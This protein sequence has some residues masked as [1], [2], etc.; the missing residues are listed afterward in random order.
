MTQTPALRLQRF[1][2]VVRRAGSLLPAAA[3]LY[4]CSSE[5][6]EPSSTSVPPSLSLIR[7]TPV[8]APAWEPGDSCVERGHDSDGSVAVQVRLTDGE[9]RAPGACGS[10]SA[11][12]HLQFSIAGADFSQSA[13]GSSASQTFSLADAPLGV[14]YTFSV[15]LADDDG[16]ALEGADGEPLSVS[17]EVELAAPG[18]C[19]GNPLPQDAGADSGSD[20]GTDAGVDSGTDAAVDSGTDAGVDSGT[21]AGVDSGAADSAS[22]DADAEAG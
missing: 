16:V 14:Q 20:S 19:G 22:A 1:R 21:D 13:R 2:K 12:G 10:R 17:A 9:L 6:T 5:S 3:L 4:A 15:T 8:G 7:I 18:S 11:C